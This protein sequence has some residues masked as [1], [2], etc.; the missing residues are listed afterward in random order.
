M[1]YINKRTLKALDVLTLRM[2]VASKSHGHADHGSDVW[3]STWNEAEY[4]HM[5]IQALLGNTERATQLQNSAQ[6]VS[7]ARSTLDTLDYYG[8]TI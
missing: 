1:A 3:H 6:V 5:A 7:E 4:C 2:K 8:V